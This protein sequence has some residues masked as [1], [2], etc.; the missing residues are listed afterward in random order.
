MRDIFGAAPA[1]TSKPGDEAFTLS[2]V[3]EQHKSNTGAV[4][5]AS[6][7]REDHPNNAPG[8]PMLMPVWLER[9]Q[10]KYINPMLRPLS[11]ACPG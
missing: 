9:M 2:I 3:P 11:N 10:I 5:S 1:A 4:M 7:S 6:T 8:V